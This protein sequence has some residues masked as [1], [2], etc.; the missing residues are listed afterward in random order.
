MGILDRFKKSS[1][2]L[3]ETAT[4]ILGWGNQKLVASTTGGPPVRAT[5]SRTEAVELPYARPGISC[6]GTAYFLDTVAK[7]PLGETEITFEVR[8][9]SKDFH[10]P[11]TSAHIFW[12]G[13]PIGYMGSVEDDALSK[14]L[15]SA[16]PVGQ[17]FTAK[18]FVGTRKVMELSAANSEIEDRKTVRAMIPAPD[19]L[20]EWFKSTPQ[21]R[22]QMELDSLQENVSLKEKQK[23]QAQ[24]SA[25]SRKYREGTF[26]AVIDIELEPS[27]KYKG[28]E[29]LVFSA[30]GLPFGKI[31]AR[32]TDQHANLFD[33]V[34]RHGTK[35]CLARVLTSNYE[36][37]DLYATASI[38][39][40][41]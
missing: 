13:K 10:P 41:S 17:A 24:L 31:G 21:Q 3:A 8:T 11:L 22:A 15:Q 26:T 14:V 1:N 16:G 30:E 33:S 12:K 39:V 32:Y 37:N 6:A 20:R 35:T 5:G 27:G 28:Q 2:P 34:L 40:F 18:A 36:P 29:C 38:K 19:L 9:N 25:L 23:Y 7:M 4:A